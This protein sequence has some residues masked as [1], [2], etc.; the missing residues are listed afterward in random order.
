MG[1]YVSKAVD[2]WAR[3]LP[4]LDTSPMLVVTRLLRAGKLFE[5]RVNALAASVGLSHKGDLDVLR[6]LRRIGEPYELA[7]SRLASFVQL[8]SGGM[9]N[10]VDRLEGLG[11]VKRRPDPSDRRGVLVGLTDLGKSTA[12][13]AIA[14]VLDSQETLLASLDDRQ[15]STMAGAL[16]SI[17]VDLGDD[18]VDL[19][20]A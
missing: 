6:A 12:E 1:D 20:P 10:R 15:R 13:R 7:P 16:E 4:D 5:D 2:D 17:L 8:T 3:E 9:T 14:L 19:S 11:M 18:S